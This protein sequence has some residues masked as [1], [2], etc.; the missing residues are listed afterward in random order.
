MRP[1]GRTVDTDV[2][3]PQAWG[4]K[5]LFSTIV[6]VL[7][8]ASAAF[9]EPCDLTGTWNSTFG[10]LEIKQDG[11]KITGKFSKE[12]NFFEKISGTIEGTMN[13]GTMEWTWTQSDGASGL[14]RW[15]VSPSCRSLDG[16]WGRSKDLE[17]N[18]FAT[19]TS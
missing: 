8:S 19:R 6:V 14:G 2:G 11:N 13:G 9:A 1:R 12:E 3:F 5:Y 10:R 15:T 4:V 17:H 18:W 7:L 16:K